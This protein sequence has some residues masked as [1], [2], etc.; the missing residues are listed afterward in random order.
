MV[1]LVLW[2]WA[3]IGVPLFSDWVELGVTDEFRYHNVFGV[4]ID[5]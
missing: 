1:E 2:V 3:V 4:I 5:T